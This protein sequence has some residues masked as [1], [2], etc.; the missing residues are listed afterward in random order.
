[1]RAEVPEAQVI[2]EQLSEYDRILA[3]FKVHSATDVPMKGGQ[4]AVSAPAAVPNP[5]EMTSMLSVT[6]LMKDKGA[7]APGCHAL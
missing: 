7:R 5:G 3:G 1:M 4:G 2:L 6:G